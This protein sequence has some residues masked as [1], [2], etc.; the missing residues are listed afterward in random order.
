M[1]NFFYGYLTLLLLSYTPNLT[2][3]LI[4]PSSSST[5]EL[6]RGWNLVGNNSTSVIDVATT[7][8][9]TTK[10]VSVWTWNN[11][12]SAWNF[13]SPFF[14]TAK[15]LDSYAA[16]KGY[17]TLHSIPP[18]N[19][20]W[21]N[22]TQPFAL[23]TSVLVATNPQTGLMSGYSTITADNP[24]LAFTP[25]SQNPSV[26]P[27]SK[28]TLTLTATDQHGA[29]MIVT[30]LS[31]AS[32]NS[33]VT[34]D[35]N[36]Q[37]TIAQTASGT[38][39]ITATEPISGVN[40]STLLNILS[41]ASPVPSSDSTTNS[42]GL[43]TW[44]LND[45]DGS[46]AFVDA[47][48]HARPWQDAT[49][50]HQPVAGVDNLGW[51]TADASTVIYSG[52]PAQINGT[53][54]LSFNGQAD[55]SLLWVAGSIS[56][57]LFD[58]KTNITTAEVTYN[59][60]SSG[61]VGLTLKNTRRNVGS[62]IN[63]GFTNMHLYRPGYATDGSAVFTTPFLAGLGKSTVVRM[64][65]WMSINENTTQHWADRLTP[66]HMSKT[67]PIYTGPGGGTWNLSQPG[68]AFEHQIQLCNALHS[69]C[70]LNIP[71]VADNEYVQNMALALR[72]GTDGTNPYHSPQTNPLY[73]PLNA[74]LR[75]YLE[76][77]NEIWNSAGG[78]NS[79]GVIQDIAGSLPAGHD[80]LIPPEP[81]IWYKMW[82]YPAYRMA[83]ISDIF[84]SVYGD[85]AMMSS[86][87]PVLMSQQGDAQATLDQA[88]E[89]LD[90]FAHRQN[91][92]REITS[93]LYGAGGSAYYGVNTWPT[94]V[95]DR[96]SFFA[97]GN[98]P[99]LQNFSGMAL[100]AIWAM[101][102][103]LKR[104]A[105]EG[106]PSLDSYPDVNASAINAD[107]RMQEMIVKSHDA[108]SNL[109]GDLLMYYNLVGPPKWEFTHDLNNSY[110]PKMVGLVQLQSQPRAPVTLGQGLPGT[111]IA[112]DEIAYRI[113]TGYDYRTT[114]DTLPCIGGNSAPTWIALPAH[115][116]TAFNGNLKVNGIAVAD[117]TLNVWVNGVKMGTVT[118]PANASLA[119]SSSLSLAIPAGLVVL[120]LEVVT[121]NFNLHSITLL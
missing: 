116:D 30:G 120:R 87:R 35:Q 25:I 121:G 18:A 83:Q 39:L 7:F 11:A 4:S 66:L 56:N 94:S 106:G 111:L 13:Y 93:Y 86:V 15:E 78:F 41:N 45:W 95:T 48:K 33:G 104:I 8:P 54:Q 69:D 44:F 31:W 77:A 1:R 53:Y 70:W 52:T 110:T 21:L 108:W 47:M 43:N 74:E 20:F 82:R 9:D 19:G 96:D 98:Y 10:V 102:Y 37:V 42:I 3:Q 23:R 117:T 28:I 105:Y 92:P 46:F 2:A 103:G 59:M 109:G 58:P 118:M 107:P 27:G 40:I 101:N 67:V 89:W 64:M 68:V 84:R 61:S 114:C 24:L 97:A 81:S 55:I 6:N 119:D 75:V 34:V 29:P 88:L 71:M 60:S 5:V 76:Y 113:R 79:F 17:L 112:T 26:V 51:P 36:G 100:D 80:L 22:V 57:Q 72:F 16:N 65:E 12:K 50:W 38:A 91:P 32:T 99:A 73:P 49:D 14:P 63:T 85:A 115:A 62:A 90:D